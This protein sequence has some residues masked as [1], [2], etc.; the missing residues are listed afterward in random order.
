MENKT[1]KGSS[2]ASAATVRNDETCKSERLCNIDEETIPKAIVPAVGTNGRA[3]DEEKGIAQITDEPITKPGVSLDCIFR[4]SGRQFINKPTNEIMQEAMNE[5]L[6]MQYWIYCLENG[7]KGFEKDINKVYKL[8]DYLNIE[9]GP[10][11]LIDNRLAQYIFNG[12]GCEHKDEEAAYDLWARAM[13]ECKKILEDKPLKG[14]EFYLASLHESLYNSTYAVGYC[15][16]YGLGTESNA[17]KAVS[18]FLECARID[19]NTDDLPFY[20]EGG[21]KPFQR[22]AYSAVIN[23]YSQGIC[24]PKDEHKAF[25]YRKHICDIGIGTSQDYINLAACYQRGIGV[26]KN[27][28]EGFKY[29]KKAADMNN[30][31][32]TDLVSDCLYNGIGVAKNDEEAQK[33]ILRGIA[34][35]QDNPWEIE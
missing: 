13:C 26:D 24:M 5:P 4:S 2:A 18:L 35:V 3:T 6:Y 28:A 14:D 20:V 11:Y 8:L 27:L 19:V 32:A 33:Y 21:W 15:T 23:I 22:Q 25:Y 34:I 17:R 30:N 9:I 10:Y 1:K 29:L 31:V 12:W 7:V 16:L